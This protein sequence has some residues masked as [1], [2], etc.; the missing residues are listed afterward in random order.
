MNNRKF[1]K[2]SLSEWMKNKVEWLTEEQWIEAY[3]KLKKPV[4]KTT[5]SAGY[6]IHLPFDIYMKGWDEIKIPTGFK[7][8]M[9]DE[10]FLGIKP[11]SGLGFK[12]YI[13]LA[14]TEGVIDAD[15]FNSPENEGHIQV[16]FRVESEVISQ[17]MLKQGDAFCQGIFYNYLLTSDD[18][19]D[20]KED[21]V[22]GFGSTTKKV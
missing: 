3:D 20:E 11:R 12:Y 17:V 15:Y 10:D 13:R 9:N 18:H 1:E 19:E 4:R 6:D 8:S 22:G 5:K 21:R 14:N 16:K 2:V 7:V